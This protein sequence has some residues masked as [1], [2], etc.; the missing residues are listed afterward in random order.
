MESRNVN[1]KERMSLFGYEPKEVEAIIQSLEHE[2]M[3][4]R[5]DRADQTQRQAAERSELMGR[6]EETQREDEQLEKAEI[7]RLGSN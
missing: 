2:L 3:L 4:Y 1:N 6:I 7:W 5:Q